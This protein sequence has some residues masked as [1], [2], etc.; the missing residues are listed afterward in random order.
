MMREEPSLPTLS[1]IVPLYNEESHLLEFLNRLRE[2]CCFVHQV[3]I[4][5]DG[6]FDRSRSIISDYEMPNGWEI[7]FHSSNMGKG[8][9]VCTGLKFVTG[10]IVIIQDADLEYF[11]CDIFTVIEKLS[12]DRECACFGSRY[13]YVPLKNP[14]KISRFRAAVGL[15]N[16]ISY[17]LY[18]QKITDQATCYKAM[19]TIIWRKLNLKSNR[20][21]IC[22]EIT[23][24]LGLL[25]IPIYEYPISYTPRTVKQGKK[26]RFF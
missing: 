20:F 8:S 4:V 16:W 22:A 18:G 13:L 17:F 23:A 26:I 19:P 25:K 21:E 10:E 6:S 2:I 7:H 3:I 9:A 15:F 14:F 12:R 11:P 5:D 1:I 24:K